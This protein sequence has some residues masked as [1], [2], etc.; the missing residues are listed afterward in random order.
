VRDVSALGHMHTLDLR[1]CHNVRD[2]NALDHVDTLRR[3]GLVI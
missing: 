2:I 3:G 1:Q